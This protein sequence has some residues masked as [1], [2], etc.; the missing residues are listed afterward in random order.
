MKQG[1]QS[2]IALLG[3]SLLCCS[4]EQADMVMPPP[5][6]SPYLY[7]G[8]GLGL[9]DPLSLEQLLERHP[10]ARIADPDAPGWGKRESW[11][12]IRPGRKQ[13]LFDRLKLDEPYSFEV[14]KMLPIGIFPSLDVMQYLALYETS[15][16]GKEQEE[17]A[18]RM[19]YL[20]PEE[21][22]YYFE[23]VGK[24]I[25][26][27]NRINWQFWEEGFTRGQDANDA[28]RWWLQETLEGD[29]Q[30]IYRLAHSYRMGWVKGKSARDAIPWYRKAY[31]KG[32]WMGPAAYELGCCY[33]DGVGVAASQREA[34]AWFRRA[35]E[36]S[37]A[38]AQYELGCCYMEGR[39][40]EHSRREAV[41]WFRQAARAGHESA[42]EALRS[43][44][45]HS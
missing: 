19:V 43:L 42:R 8:S 25:E 28:A 6:C 3:A 12:K 32:N 2:W 37:H 1:H 22:D 18:G 33:R 39:G 29:T 36:E 16:D 27:K 10:N 20:S 4:C 24:R 44:E 40:V 30:Y 23:R 35:A 13:A 31:E 21:M 41:K 45:E 38:E 14:D 7:E 15:P 17:I 34:A 5:H 26:E 11:L 9:Y